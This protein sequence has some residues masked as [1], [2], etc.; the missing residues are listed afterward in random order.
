MVMIIMMMIMMMMMMTDPGALLNVLT[1]HTGVLYGST[2]KKEVAT[3]LLDHE[4]FANVP[5]TLPVRAYMP[6]L[7]AMGLSWPAWKAGRYG[8]HTNTILTPH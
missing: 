7:T 1:P 3:F 4:G 6:S 2:T 8:R 5:K